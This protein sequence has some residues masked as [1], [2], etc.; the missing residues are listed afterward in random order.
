VAEWGWVSRA[1]YLDAIHRAEAA[2]ARE[3]YWRDRAERV[4][5]AALARAGAIHEPAWSQTLRAAAPDA[6]LQAF[7][8]LAVTEIDS[9]RSSH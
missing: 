2:E 4:T 1:R 6:V 8:G 5:D 7:R 3:S 9:S